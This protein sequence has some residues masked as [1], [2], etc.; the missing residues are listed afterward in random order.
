MRVV[1]VFDTNV[2]FS[3]TGWHGKP[4]QCLEL[5]QGT[6]EGVTCRE[7]LEELA[8]KLSERLRFSPEEVTE[9]LTDL[10]GA[11]RVVAIAGRLHGATLIPMTTRCSNARSPRA[12]LTL[13]RVTA[14]T[15]YPS[16]AIK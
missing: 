4:Y 10:L 16:R 12:Q 6:I 3:A 13:S 8:E 11:L 9:T 1:A 15:C 5:A 7:L 14:D 2:L